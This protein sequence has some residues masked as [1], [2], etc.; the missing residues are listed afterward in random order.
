MKNKPNI[1]NILQGQSV[2]NFVAKHAR[3]FNVAAV[4][5]DRKKASKAGKRKHKGKDYDY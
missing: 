3:T 1:N 2:N 4:H 5:E